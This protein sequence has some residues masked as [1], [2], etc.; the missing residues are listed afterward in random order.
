MS[1]VTLFDAYMN[2]DAVESAFNEVFG[3]EWNEIS[4]NVIYVD[5]YTYLVMNNRVSPYVDVYNSY[6]ENHV[7]KFHGIT[8]DTHLERVKNTF[9]AVKEFFRKEPEEGQ[10]KSFLT[11]K[12][13]IFWRARRSTSSQTFKFGN[14]YFEKKSRDFFIIYNTLDGSDVTRLSQWNSYNTEAGAQARGPYTQYRDGNYYLNSI[15]T[16]VYANNTRNYL[17]VGTY[18]NLNSELIRRYVLPEEAERDYLTNEWNG[19]T[20]YIDRQRPEASYFNTDVHGYSTRIEAV[21]SAEKLFQMGEIDLYKGRDRDT[22]PFL[23]WELEACTPDTSNARKFKELLPFQIMCKS[24]SSISPS[25][26]ETVSIPATLDFWKESALAETLNTMRSAP[27]NMRSFKHSSCGFHVHVS[28]AALSVLDLNKIERFV[29]NPENNDFMKDIAGRGPNTYANYHPELFT[30]RKSQVVV[31]NNSRS[32]PDISE[33]MMESYSRSFHL[34]TPYQ[35]AV[36]TIWGYVALPEPMFHIFLSIMM[37]MDE[38][39][40]KAEEAIRRTIEWLN[41]GEAS[42]WATRNIRKIINYFIP[43]LIENAVTTIG[44][45]AGFDPVSK[46]N[47]PFSRKQSREASRLVKGPVGKQ[48]KGRYDVLNT[49][50]EHTVEF[51]LFK[52]TM[53]PDSVFRYLE[54]VDAIVR[55]VAQ[56]GAKDEF[57]SFNYFIGWLISDSFNITRYEKLVAF[58]V[59]K[60]YIDRKKI[61]RRKVEYA[62]DNNAN[63]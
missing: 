14:K 23:G 34:H 41:S 3:F 9:I 12:S 36:N 30:D 42:E 48:S 6:G 62:L 22:V 24:D 37:S 32:T 38:D 18:L 39:A 35:K 8:G 2:R 10:V 25:G 19:Q 5:A 31:R 63:S 49:G 43:G 52:G 21:V 54:F 13:E 29:H 4:T 45:W 1:V 61:R 15:L 16:P 26:F 50:N 17:E 7:K 55:Y 57:L 60:G 56:A 44:K 46:V 33:S 53:N 51:R 20:F 58:L 47:A 27:H 59:E 11:V 40:T 28:R